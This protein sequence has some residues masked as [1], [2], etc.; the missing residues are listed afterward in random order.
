M[1]LT[2][3]LPGYLA[4]VRLGAATAFAA[5]SVL[6]GR[7]LFFLLVI[8]VLRA[9][10]DVVMAE[11]VD[12]SLVADLPSS[13]LLLYVGM[14]EW[15][16]LS[17]PAIHLRLEDDLRSGSIEGMLLR[18]R[19]PLLARLF[20]MIGVLIVRLTVLGLAGF[21]GLALIGEPG[22]PPETLPALIIVGLLGGVISLQIFALVG[23]TSF[24]LRRNL[25]VYLGMQ[26][27]CFLF[28]GL[29]APISLYPDWLKRFSELTPFAA[30]LYW[31]SSLALDFSRERLALALFAQFSW[32]TLLAL[33]LLFTWR[34]GLRRILVRGS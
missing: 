8:S 14:T 33:A 10:W 20:E 6:F 21:A 16:T 25:A 28:G 31:P 27:M 22:F 32:I 12:G 3:G 23:I 4:L 13:S 9:F 30:H 26:K 11:H 34:A 1:T 15:I 7:C 29:F 19:S 18:P 2:R 5:P 24:W 17:V